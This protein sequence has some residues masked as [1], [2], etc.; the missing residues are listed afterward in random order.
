MAENRQEPNLA[1]PPEVGNR[2]YN[3]RRHVLQADTLS[4]IQ[5]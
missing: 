2:R 3:L 5:V 4:S 1:D